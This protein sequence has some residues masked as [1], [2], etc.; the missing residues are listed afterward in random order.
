M[1]IVVRVKLEPS[2]CQAD[3][4]AATLRGCNRAANHVSRVAFESGEKRRSG[5][6]PLVYRQVKDEF[7]LSA[8]PTVRVV[9][10]VCDA[11]ATLKANIRAGNLQIPCH[12]R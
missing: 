4:L 5:L 6:Q 3:A 9:K 8:Q 1:K 11:Y 12:D 10:K 2:A 7:D